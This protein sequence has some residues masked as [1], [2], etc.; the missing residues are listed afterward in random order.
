MKLGPPWRLSR[1]RM[2]LVHQLAPSV[3]SVIAP[4]PMAVVMAVINAEPQSVITTLVMLSFP[5]TLMVGLLFFL[6]RGFG[7]IGWASAIVAGLIAGSLM[8]NFLGM[9][10]PPESLDALRADGNPQPVGV[11]G[12]VGSFLLP[13]LVTALSF[14]SVIRIQCWRAFVDGASDENPPTTN[15]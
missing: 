3:A 13:G 15:G 5:M 12:A 10:P 7:L 4:L 2:A 1:E 9:V 11:P 8:M 14:W 6:A